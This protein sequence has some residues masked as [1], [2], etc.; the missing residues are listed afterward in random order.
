MLIIISRKVR[1]TI[2]II[3]FRIK[4]NREI[5]Y[6]RDDI[7]DIL[8][9]Y[10][11]IESLFG[12]NINFISFILIGF[13]RKG[14][15]KYE[16]V[17]TNKYIYVI[18]DE[19]KFNKD[20]FEV[21]E[22]YH[23]ILYAAGNDYKLSTNE[24]LEYLK[25]KAGQLRLYYVK[26][27]IKGRSYH[28]L[29]DKKIIKNDGLNK[30]ICN[31]YDMFDLYSFSFN[32]K[33]TDEVE[34]VY[35]LYKFIKDY[36]LLDEKGIEVE[37]YWEILFKYSVLF[38]ITK[39]IKEIINQK[40]V[41]DTYKNIYNETIFKLMSMNAYKQDEYLEEIKNECEKHLIASKK[42]YKEKFEI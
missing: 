35:G 23:I 10:G 34:K 6:Y 7:D 20:D 42:L 4:A 32:K 33:Y 40:Y 41:D 5:E 39:N 25:S 29:W 12:I 37:S 16:R 14:W 18:G 1:H 2:G 26:S 3:L 9:Y 22:F 28:Y 17:A 21:E 31:A 13:V 11:L 19:P 36:T 38:N 27:M 30:T 15:L 8:L 24:L